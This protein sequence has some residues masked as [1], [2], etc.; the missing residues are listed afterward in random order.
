MAVH[1][2]TTGGHTVQLGPRRLG[3]LVASRPAGMAGIGVLMVL[4]GAWAGIVGY[5]GPL[6]GYHAIAASAWQWTRAN[7][8][9]HLVPGAA[10]VFAGLSVLIQTP[11]RRAV[12]RPFAIAGLVAVAAGAWLVVGP[13]ASHIFE[14]AVTYGPADGHLAAFVNQVGANL[15]PGLLLAVLGGMALKALAPDQPVEVVPASAVGMAETAPTTEFGTPPVQ[16]GASE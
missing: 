15:G 4:V 11:K 12:A 2:A 10:G 8:L 14:S 3:A 1:V 5:V 7:W 16:A 9:L 6:F 13:A